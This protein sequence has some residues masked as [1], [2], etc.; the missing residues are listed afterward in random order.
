MESF[1]VEN[2]C[3][4]KQIGVSA[5]TRNNNQ[6]VRIA[7]SR[8]KR[9]RRAEVS[10]LSTGENVEQ[11][12][13]TDRA[14]L[15]RSMLRFLHIFTPGPLYVGTRGLEEGFEDSIVLGSREILP[16]GWRPP[17]KEKS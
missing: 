5:H 15:W 13:A 17:P 14:R 1:V 12:I 7:S 11:S 3:Q 10:P 8:K 2:F 9:Y 6:G 4:N 16:S